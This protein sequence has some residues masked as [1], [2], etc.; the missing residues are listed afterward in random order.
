MREKFLDLARELRK[1]W[2]MRKTM[3]PIVIGEL[4]TVPRVLERGLE[5]LE[6]QGRIEIIQTIALWSARILRRVL[7]SFGN[8]F[9]Q[10]WKTIN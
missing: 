2:N 8:M 3:I 5:K 9:R 7:E 1:L 10:L 4:E 6:I